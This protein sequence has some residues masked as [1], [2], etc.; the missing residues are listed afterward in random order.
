M[1][2]LAGEARIKYLL[3]GE[4]GIGYLSD[5]ESFRPH[6]NECEECQASAPDVDSVI[7]KIEQELLAFI[8]NNIQQSYEQYCL[9]AAN[10]GDTVKEESAR[11]AAEFEKSLRRDNEENIVFDDL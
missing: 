6:W 5:I 2:E 7:K 1:L 3:T 11:R 9:E 8:K 10:M 4:E